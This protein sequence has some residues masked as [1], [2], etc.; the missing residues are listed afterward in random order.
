MFTIMVDCGKFTKDEIQPFVVN[1]LN[2][3][4]DILVVTHIDNDHVDGLCE[5]LT[6]LPNLYIGKIFYNCYQLLDGGVIASMTKVVSDDITMLSQNLPNKKIEKEGKINMEHASTLAS[7][8]MKNEGWNASWNKL[9]YVESSMEPHPL[10][11]GFGRLVFL[12]PTRNEIDVLNEQFAREYMRLTRHRVPSTP[13]E[14]SETLFELVSRLVSMK[15]KEREYIKN[16]KIAGVVDKYSPERWSAAK[17]FNPEGV[18]DENRASIAFI[19]EFGDTKVL[20]MGDAEPDIVQKAIEDKYGHPIIFKAIKVSHHGSKHSTS[21]ALMAWVDSRDYFFTGGSK[22]DKPSLEAL[23]KIV[24][25]GDNKIRTLHY[26]YEANSLMNNMSSDEC[27]YIRNK[28]NFTI[29]NQ[30]ELEFEY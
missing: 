20:F 17:A 1:E 8:I 28:Y 9:Y 30:N 29:S 10:G 2:S 22:S 4:I 25:R 13:F 12:S 26:N 19:W 15:C 18:S 11:D 7:I 23:S 24:D 3:H 6:S 14:G 5:M 21:D 16:H 27:S